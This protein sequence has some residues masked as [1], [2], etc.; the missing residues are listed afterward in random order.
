MITLLDDFQP[1]ENLARLVQ[2]DSSG[3]A[4]GSPESIQL[5]PGVYTPYW[6][7][8][9]NL[10]AEGYVTD[11]EFY[12]NTRKFLVDKVSYREN[13]FGKDKVTTLYFIPYLLDGEEC[14]VAATI[15]Y[16]GVY[17]VIGHLST[18]YIDEIFDKMYSWLGQGYIARTHAVIE[19]TR[20]GC[21]F[22]RKLFP[23]EFLDDDTDA[24]LIGRNQQRVLQ[25]ESYQ[26]V[27]KALYGDGNNFNYMVRL[28]LGVFDK[29]TLAGKPK[30]EVFTYDDNVKLG[31]L[32]H[33]KGFEVYPFVKRVVDSGKVPYV[34][35]YFDS[36]IK[37]GV[38]IHKGR[39]NLPA[40]KDDYYIV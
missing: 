25:H 29:G 19:T 26:H 32:Y 9:D 12:E 31:E 1:P 10:F 11:I 14:K 34:E 15:L 24:L 35:F 27:L 16:E 33:V 4:W 40:P 6:V 17:H 3:G 23:A 5:K 30:V 39:V 36:S 2:D 28:G 22:S 13:Y 8:H 7:R 20:V 18:Y 21:F 37:N 38:I